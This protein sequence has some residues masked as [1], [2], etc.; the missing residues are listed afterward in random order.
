ME[1]RSLS[2]KRDQAMIDSFYVRAGIRLDRGVT[3]LYG[4]FEGETLLALGGIA[5]NAIR[6]LAVEESRQG[7]GILPALVTHLYQQMREND[8]TNVFVITKPQ[9]TELF[10]SLCFNE[11]AQTQDAALL[12]SSNNA[13]SRYLARLPQADGAIVMNADPFTLGHRYLVETACAQC[14]RLNVFVLSSEAAHVPSAVRLRLV[15]EGCRDLANVQV[16]EGGDYIIS[17]ATFPDYFFKDKNEA[18]LAYARLDATL[19]ARRIAPACGIQTRFVGKEPLDPM[20]A[21]YN[22]TLCAILPE[23]GIAVRVIPRREIDGSPISASRVRALW[24]EA[25]YDEIAPLVPESTLDYIRGNP[26]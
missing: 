26:L 3:A 12:E 14:A 11:L 5:G 25:R 10:S 6:S 1:I 19:F 23:H 7:E 22:E 4:A 17:G 18:A 9:Y 15:R 2:L 20:T 24:R 8:I 21:A 13:F 16:I